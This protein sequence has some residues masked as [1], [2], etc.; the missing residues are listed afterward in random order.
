M[1]IEIINIRID[2]KLNHVFILPL[3]KKSSQMPIFQIVPLLG[4]REIYTLRQYAMVGFWINK[5]KYA[6]SFQSGRSMIIK[7]QLGKENMFDSCTDFSNNRLM[8][9]FLFEKN[10]YMH[11]CIYHV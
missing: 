4:T 9:C 10:V 6:F 8:K 7:G 1:E 11:K 5:D 2:T 3:F